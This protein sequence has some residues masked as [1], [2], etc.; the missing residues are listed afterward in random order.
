MTMAQVGFDHVTPATPI[1]P[2]LDSTTVYFIEP[3][4]A[5]TA[6]GFYQSVASVVPTLTGGATW[7]SMAYGAGVWV[8][9]PSSGN[10]SAYSTTGSTWTAATL[11]LATTW[12]T[13]AYGN[14]YFVALNSSNA[15]GIYSNS[16]GLGWRTFTMPSNVPWSSLVYSNGVFVAIASG[17]NVAAY[18]TNFVRGVVSFT[19]ATLP[20]ASTWTNLAVGIT[21]VAGTSST[22]FVT[23]AS[24]TNTGAY[25]VNF[26]A[27]WLNIS[28]PA[29]AVWSSVTFGNG[30]FVAIS[31]FSA[32]PPLYSFDGIN[33]LQSPIT[34]FGTQLA[35]GQGIF[36]AVASGSSTAYVSENG[37]DW[38]SRTVTADAY[39]AVAFGANASYQ[40]I[41]ATLAGTNT[42]SL[43]SAGIRTKGRVSITSNSLAS[44]SIFE[45]G[46]GYTTG[47]NGV[48]SLPTVSITDPNVTSLATQT[49][50][51][52]NGVLGNPTFYNKGSGYNSTTTSVLVTGNGFADTFQTGFSII[53]NN[54]TALPSPGANLTITGNN[55]VYKVTSAS[56]V[57]GT[58][59][60]NLQVNVAIS[61]ALTITQ[62]PANGIAVQIRVKYSQCRL[63]NH[64]FLNIGFGDL[65][66]SNYPNPIPLAGYGS[67]LNNQFVEVNFGRVF[68]TSTDQ[69]GNFK[70]GNLFG[71][72]QATG[73]ITLS[74][75]QFGLGGLSSLSLG[76]IALGSSSVLISQFSTDSSFTANSDAVIPT[77]RAIRSYLSSRLSQGGANTFT[78]QIT[79]GT[80]VIG[81]PNFIRSSIP[82]GQSG[83][84]VNMLS[85]VYVNAN[86]VDGNMVALNFFIRNGSHRS[87]IQ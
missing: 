53:L 13:V 38:G 80:V 7:S 31:S 69:D 48:A 16:R 68:V 85:K 27:T 44:I 35:Y 10:T 43:I 46:S 57:Y 40:G 49:P 45:P 29:S 1:V 51:V 81:G 2:S 15:T 3:R 8:A 4:L 22:V 65:I 67:Y 50:R 75:S 23:L 83:S 66:E 56:A 6:P 73:I 5:F 20:S 82:N 74:A 9:V 25:S 59:V 37:L 84:A 11:P 24:G 62:S 41:F 30:R 76:G 12:S 58:T 19:G 64:D 42:G 34:A 61:P 77:Q 17:Y 18:A 52:A 14:G 32:Q 28:L 87:L 55:T 47:I 60:P 63:T 26:G 78:G 21:Q 39:S 72:Q 71:V 86:G 33:W 70:V 36:L 54:I 79:A